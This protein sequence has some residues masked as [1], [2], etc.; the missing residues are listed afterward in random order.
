[1]RTATALLLLAALVVLGSF[2]TP[3]TQRGYE[4]LLMLTDV[5]HIR[6]PTMLDWRSDVHQSAITYH[7]HHRTY[8]ADLY[9]ADGNPKAGIVLVH[10]AAAQGKDDPRLKDFAMMLARARFAVLVPDLV[11]LRQQRLSPSNTQ[12][13]KNTLEYVLSQGHLSPNNRIGIGAFSVAVGPAVLA[14]LDPKQADR[15]Q[16][17]LAVGG[18]YDLPRTLTYLTTGYYGGKG[19]VMRRQPS[20]DGRWILAMSN[21]H[22]LERARDREVLWALA[23]RKL[24]APSAPV[25]ELVQELSEAGRTVYAFVSNSDPSRAMTLLAQ[26]PEPIRTDI[27][28][29]DIASQDLSQLKAQLILVHGMDDAVIPYPESQAMGVAAPADAAR[30]F[31]LR[32]L[33]HVDTHPEMVDG[34]TLWRAIY[35]LLSERDRNQVRRGG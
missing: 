26:L 28:N 32:G 25:E 21:A 14:A 4:A 15:V 33:F 13:V 31:L 6:V 19:F 22:R 16:F 17:V 11:E 9:R 24:D 30:L 8:A 23:Q 18:Y 35:A 7:I 12:D 27:Q 2:L 34:F 10:G 29:L 3:Y 1:M 5:A 20:D